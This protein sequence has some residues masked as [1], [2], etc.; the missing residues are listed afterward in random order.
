MD[1]IGDP[2]FNQDDVWDVHWGHINKE[3]GTEDTGKWLDEDAGWTS[4]P[5]SISVPFQPCHGQPSPMGACACNNSVGEFHHRKL[6]SVIKEKITGLKVTHQFHFEPC[7]LLWHPPH[8]P[9]P[10]N[11]QGELYSPP[12]LIDAHWDIQDSPGE[13][14]CDLP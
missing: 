3:L 10:V 1:I 11:V 6:V 7:E 12:A 9:E 8:L 5:V 4:T 13:P 14:G 2:E